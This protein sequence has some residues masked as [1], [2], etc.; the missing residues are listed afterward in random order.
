MPGQ[1]FGKFCLIRANVLAHR[2]GLAVAT[3]F[4]RLRRWE[5]WI[6]LVPNQRRP[7]KFDSGLAS[8]LF[9]LV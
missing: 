7:T 4:A 9:G 1:Q 6:H 5:D 8:G 2:L 3:K